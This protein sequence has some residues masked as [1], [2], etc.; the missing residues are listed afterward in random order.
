[1]KHF[2]WLVLAVWYIRV[3][4]QETP[5]P[6]GN[7]SPMVKA[8]WKQ[9]APF[10][11]LCPSH[12]QDGQTVHDLAG[13]GPL[14]MAQLMHFH[15]YPE[16][17]PDKT[18][19]YEWEQMF[20]RL[21][22]K[23]SVD[24]IANV[25]KLISDC[26]VTT[27]TQY[28][29]TN[30][31]S[32]MRQ[33][34]TALKGF[35]HYSKYMYCVKR[36]QLKARGCDEEFRSLLLAELKAGRP[37]IYRGTKTT[38]NNDDDGHIFIIDGYKNGKVHVNMG[39]ADKSSDYYDLDDLNGYS[40]HH[41]MIVGIADSSYRPR[42]KDIRLNTPGTVAS[43]IDTAD[44]HLRIT[45]PMNSTD[46]AALR[47]L[48]IEKKRIRSIDL[49]GA[50]L[51]GNLPDRAF[52]EC[53]SL[54][55]VALPPSVTYIGQMAFYKCDALNRIDLPG[56]LDAIGNRAFAYC[57][58]LTSFRLPETLRWIGAQAFYGC[59]SLTS[60]R[61]PEGVEYVDWMAFGRAAHLNTVH[62][63]KS[64]RRLGPELTLNCPALVRVTLPE[65]NPWLESD[66]LRIIPKGA[67]VDENN[68]RHIRLKRAGTLAGLLSPSDWKIR[69][70]GPVNNEDIAALRDM[71]RG[72][73]ELRDIDLRETDLKVVPRSAFVYCKKIRNVFLPDGLERIEDFAFTQ[74]KWLERIDIPSTVT[75][76][77][78]YVF[79]GCSELK[80]VNFH[81][82][83]SRLRFIGTGAFD[84]CAA[85]NAIS[86]PEGLETLEGSIFR[87]CT[88]LHTLHF[89][90][91]LKRVGGGITAG[92]TNLKNVTIAPDNLSYK[93]ENKQLK[94]RTTSR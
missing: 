81:P 16:T 87:N 79:S 24:R 4:A 3:Q 82:K 32:N 94:P 84:N 89:P 39:W 68:V 2:V 18:T 77:Q 30:S 58:Y 17:S 25:A 88:D 9:Q 67:E 78:T 93:V 46:I 11:Q 53:S 41:W 73:N 15:H 74:C 47:Q 6:T 44:L 83:N 10:N 48:A 28:G 52:A 5:I 64:L 7:I 36:E 12:K 55:Y 35:F 59:N 76:I 20:R 49:S 71:A 37:V 63:P 1:M 92:C 51:S 56:T 14:A 8:Q 70:T 57:S 21:S 22:D 33:I 43:R 45:G 34:T 31:T 66:G 61:I 85:L 23:T 69:I 86:L 65:D 90:K 42:I 40:H 26:G 29:L 62:L 38:N 27:F 54:V 80:E 50:T 91:S 13:C 75:S 72:E 19:R 60:V